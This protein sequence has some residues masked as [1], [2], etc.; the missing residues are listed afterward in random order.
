MRAKRT[1]LAAVVACGLGAPTLGQTAVLSVM[2]NDPDGLV[3]PG[4]SVRIY[5]TIE[6]SGAVQIAGVAGSLLAT[7]NVGAAGAPYTPLGGILVNVGMASG[8][9]IEG[10]DVASVPPFFTGGLT[11]PGWSLSPSLILEYQWT[12][13]ATPGVVEF[14]FVA[15]P[16]APN[17]RLYAQLQSPAFTEAQ[18]TYVG[19]SLT[20]V[21]SVGVLWAFGAAGFAGRPKRR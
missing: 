11:L 1:G 20:V 12:A 13:P 7:P 16:L 9:G 6:Y 18:T 19:A 3:E 8:G 17:V 15:S 10:Y 14:D 21:P 4:Q 5:A 2:H